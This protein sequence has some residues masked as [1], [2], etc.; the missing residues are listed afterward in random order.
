MSQ[1][2]MP[3]I[4]QV[5]FSRWLVQEPD[6]TLSKTGTARLTVRIAVNRTY[7]DRNDVW[8]EETF[9]FDI[10]LWQKAAESFSQQL[11][12]VTPVFASGRLH[13]RTWRDAD[14]KNHHKIDIQVRNLQ[15]L[16]RDE[17]ENPSTDPFATQANESLTAA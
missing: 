7:R 5:A 14:E 4:N 2:K 12:K 16:E 11:H 10:I 15:I 13:S 6:F 8:Q 3:N 17:P 1:L 9:F